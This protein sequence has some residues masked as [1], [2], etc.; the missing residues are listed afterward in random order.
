LPIS[1]ASFPPLI[2]Y[3]PTAFWDTS[4]LADKAA[5]AATA[6]TTAQATSTFLA[7]AVAAGAKIDELKIDWATLAERCGLPLRD[8]GIEQAGD[9]DP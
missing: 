5:A 9:L 6:L 2:S 3:A 8:R 7:A 4:E 1:T